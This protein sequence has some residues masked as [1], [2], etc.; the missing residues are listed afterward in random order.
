MKIKKYFPLILVLTLFSNLVF[1]QDLSCTFSTGSEGKWDKDK[2][3]INSVIWESGPVN[4]IKTGKASNEYTMQ[5]KLGNIPLLSKNTG[6]GPTYVSQQMGYPM[7][8]SVF[9][10]P[11]TGTNKYYAVLSRHTMLL[12]TPLPTQ[13]HGYCIISKK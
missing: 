12:L 4:I 3:T 2:V 6:F 1:A 13:Y 5:S 10:T 11:I 8:I 7:F 9:D